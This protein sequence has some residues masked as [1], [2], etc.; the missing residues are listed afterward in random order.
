MMTTTLM[1]I[2]TEM[3]DIEYPVY[4]KKNDNSR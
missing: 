1:D 3:I 2:L 4:D